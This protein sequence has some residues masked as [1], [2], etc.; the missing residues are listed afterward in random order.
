MGAV[1]AVSA[2]IV[3]YPRIYYCWIVNTYAINDARGS[4][5]LMWTL[6][7]ERGVATFKRDRVVAPDEPY[8]QLKVPRF[9]FYAPATRPLDSRTFHQDMATFK[10]IWGK[11]K[12]FR[13]LEWNDY[14]FYTAD[15]QHEPGNQLYTLWLVPLPLSPIAAIT[16]MPP[17]V[18]MFLASRRYLK[19]RRNGLCGLCVNCGYD[20]RSTPDR[21]P[22]CGVIPAKA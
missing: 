1:I 5:V 2:W 21:C 6:T 4:V 13:F 15:T 7:A 10:T 16:A 12:T 14:G 3:S 20:L 8:S 19:R 18:W 22:E 9:H 17:L 11:N